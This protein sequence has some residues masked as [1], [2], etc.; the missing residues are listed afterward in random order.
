MGLT[1]D[2]R[3]A[4]STTSQL[5]YVILCDG[6]LQL[7]Y[8]FDPQHTPALVTGYHLI[9]HEVTPY[10]ARFANRTFENRT[11]DASEHAPLGA[12]NILRPEPW[13]LPLVVPGRWDRPGT[14]AKEIWDRISSGNWNNP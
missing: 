9:E 8:G 14:E 4:Q 12:N 3:G 5:P 6:G 1:I 2:P 11:Y 13:P 7:G 10:L